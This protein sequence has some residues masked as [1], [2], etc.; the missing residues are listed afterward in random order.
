[1]IIRKILCA[2]L[3]AAVLASCA[4][5]AY[6]QYSGSSIEVMAAETVISFDKTSLSV[7]LKESIRLNVK[8]DTAEKISWTSSDDN[9]VSVKDGTITGKAKGT[10]IITARLDSGKMAKCLITVKDAPKNITITKSGITL[11]V[12]ESY[13]VGSGINDG[14][15]CATRIYSSGDSNIVHMDTTSWVGKFTA[16]NPG[17]TYVTVRSYNG[18][19]ASCKVTVRNAPSKITLTKGILTLGAGESYTLGSNLNS[20]AAAADRTYRTSNSS[21]V[22]MTNT[23]WTGKFTAMK[24]GTA[25]VTVRT[26]NGK[27]ASCKVVVKAAPA[28]VNLSRGMIYKTP[29]QEETLSVILPSGTGS[30]HLS[31]R[32]SNSSVAKI[33]KTDRKCVFKAVGKGTAYITVRTYNGKEASC[34][35]VVKSSPDKVMLSKTKLTLKVGKS[36]ELAASVSQDAYSSQYTFTASNNSIIKIIPSGS[37]CTVK[38]LKKGTATVTVRTFNGK[39]ASCKITVK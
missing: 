16:K 23:K 32:T 26:Y 39:T 15:A 24:V 30:E 29:G 36:A 3:S 10:A 34:K 11:G 25:Y 28:K 4:V 22:K 1:M 33:V 35:V 7:G 5:F 19:T 27:E 13:S 9:T 8:T 2:A 12:G 21:V 37:R 38:A 20:G 17:T 18:R 6:P 31:F 14:A